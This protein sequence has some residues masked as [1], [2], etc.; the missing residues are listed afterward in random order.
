MKS[1]VKRYTGQ[2]AEG[3]QAQEPLSVWSWDVPPFQNRDV[4]TN[5]ETPELHC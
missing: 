1:Q 2:G 4:F 3:S 5:S